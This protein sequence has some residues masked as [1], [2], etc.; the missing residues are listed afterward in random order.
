MTAPVITRNPLLA[1]I[2]CEARETLH[3]GVVHCIHAVSIH[4]S[5]VGFPILEQG[6]Q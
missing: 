5:Y 3:H 2:G 4:S 1:Q 6:K